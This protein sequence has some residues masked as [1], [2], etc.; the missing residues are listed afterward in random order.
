AMDVLCQLAL[1]EN[2]YVNLYAVEA[3][4][5]RGDRAALP[6]LLAVLEH[7]DARQQRVDDSF[8]RVTQE[9]L[10]AIREMADGGTMLALRQFSDRGRRVFE[11]DV[12]RTISLIQRDL[13]APATMVERPFDGGGIESL[14]R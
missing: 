8:S 2:R 14:L 1:D 7:D 9:T 4:R 11:Q 6:T 12:Q 10:R 13:E 3:L 5:R